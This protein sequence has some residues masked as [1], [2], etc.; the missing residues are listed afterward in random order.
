MENK[1]QTKLETQCTADRRQRKPAEKAGPQQTGIILHR[2]LAA[3]L[4]GA[5]KMQKIRLQNL[6]KLAPSSLTLPRHC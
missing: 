2:Q 4:Q 1:Q 6:R 5:P 3:F